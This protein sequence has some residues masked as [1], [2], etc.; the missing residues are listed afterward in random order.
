M[1]LQDPYEAWPAV[2]RRTERL[3]FG[4]VV[5]NPIMRHFT[6]T[7]SGDATLASI[8]PV[9]VGLGLGRGDSSIRHAGLKPAKVADMRELAARDQA[10]VG[11]PSRSTS[12]EPRSA[13]H[14]PG[15]GFR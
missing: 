10:P 7:A 12:R 14:G 9:G 2:W 8:H 1:I 6:V 3:T 15:P 11:R 4:T 13:S 5:T